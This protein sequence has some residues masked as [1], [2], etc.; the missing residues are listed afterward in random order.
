MC[1]AVSGFFFF[2]G[3]G[4]LEDIAIMAILVLEE[5]KNSRLWKNFVLK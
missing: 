4:G 5:R 2:W 3:G 1:L